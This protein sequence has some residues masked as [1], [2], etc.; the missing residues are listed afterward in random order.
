MPRKIVR[1]GCSHCGLEFNEAHH[2]ALCEHRHRLEAVR[3]AASKYG[4]S[5]A[6]LDMRV[7]S[8]GRVQSLTPIDDIDVDSLIPR[9]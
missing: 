7:D 9:G 4:V 5:W 6:D 1:Y 2:A 8:R 3:V